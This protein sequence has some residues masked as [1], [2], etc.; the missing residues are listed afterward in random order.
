[1]SQDPR[2]KLVPQE[3]AFEMKAGSAS[4]GP[5]RI[6]IWATRLGR[7]LAFILAVLMIAQ[8]GQHFLS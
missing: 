4:A 1:M 7:L 5:D 8:L 3:P 2:Q 6:E